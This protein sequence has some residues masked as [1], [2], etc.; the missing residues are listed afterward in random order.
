M[1]APLF[2]VAELP[3][4]DDYR[5]DGVEGHHAATVQRLGPGEAL[6]L[7][8]GLGGIARCRVTRAGKGTLDLAVLARWREPRPQPRLTVAQAIAKGERGELAV[9]AMTEV[10]VDRIIPW[11][12]ARSVARW[13]DDRGE[14]ALSRWR[15]VAREAS[16]QA[17]R[18]WQPVIP[19]LMDTKAVRALVGSVTA[20]YLL[21]EE[22]SLPLATVNLPDT[23]EILLVVGPEGGVTPEETATFSA[24]GGIPVRLGSTVL[25]TSTA[26]VA[27]LSVVSA[28]TGRWC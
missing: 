20:A 18:A 23:G 22:A 15:S 25:R 6:L 28:R 7:G 27:A 3:P 16:K 11:S 21:H 1:G 19:E 14:R 8:D 2:L 17:R 5:L 24:A 9:Q 4:A 13:K 26:G 12:A 10:G